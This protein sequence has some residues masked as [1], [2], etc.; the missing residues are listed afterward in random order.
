MEE[1]YILWKEI[2]GRMVG[3]KTDEVARRKR[4]PRKGG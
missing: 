1:E 4:M 2:K 3:G